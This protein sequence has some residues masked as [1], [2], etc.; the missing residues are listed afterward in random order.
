MT[1]STNEKRKSIEA[2][3]EKLTIERQCELVGISRSGYYY[4]PQMTN[5]RTL[6]MIDIVDETYTRYPFFGTRKMASYLKRN[7]YDIGRKRVKTIYEILGLEAVY[8]KPKLSMPNKENKIYPYL[9]RDLEIESR[10]QVWSTDITY[11]RL[12]SGFVYL[13][14]V[15]DW[16]SRYV[17]DWELSISLEADFCIDTL[18]RIL[19]TSSRCKIFNTDQGSQF[20]SRGFTEALLERDIQ[21]SMDGRGRAL[22][23]IFVERLWRSLKYE[24]IYMRS[25]NTLKE[26]R[27]EIKE[28]FEFYNN[29][30]PHQSL[31]NKTPSE[32]Y[33]WQ[34]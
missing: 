7:G 8:P 9:L 29:D 16:Y 28:Y 31:G 20:T 6:S 22:D 19:G 5:K 26:A 1:C 17:L 25:L 12:N 4:K 33:M 27:K 18:K 2:E 14:A 3:H 32:I 21:I 34:K 24:C 13:M 11:I 23:N 15:I 30:R 10:D